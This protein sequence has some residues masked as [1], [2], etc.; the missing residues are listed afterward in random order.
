[1]A[2]RNWKRRGRVGCARG[3]ERDQLIPAG[4]ASSVERSLRSRCSTAP[5]RHRRRSIAIT[6]LGTLL[7]SAALSYELDGRRAQFSHALLA[8]PIWVLGL[9]ALCHLTSLLTRS[10][11]WR[12]SVHAAGGSVS[13]RVLFRAAGIGSLA[14]VLSAQLGVAARIGV[15]RRSAPDACPRIPALIAAEVPILAVEAMLA[16]LFMF[17]LVGPLGL[18]VWV[19]VLVIAAMLLALCGLGRFARRHQLGLWQGLAAM[20]NLHGRG[21]LIAFVVFGVLAQIAR[22]LLILHAVGVDASVFDAIA[23]LIVTVSLSP[24]PIGPSVG[25]AATVLILGSH[26][27]AATAAGG[28]LLTV[29]GI[30]GSLCFAG[31]AC[32]DLALTSLRRSRSVAAVAAPAVELSLLAPTS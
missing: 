11:A 9:A 18:P 32:G 26:G 21:R 13:R 4:P 27:I 10:E 2:Q 20:R 8:V 1:M 28:V 14:S 29:T 22:N 24:L 30:V 3:Q 17:T 25:A 16:A 31:W 19:P 15:L 7:V 5:S 12:V 6:V 23:V